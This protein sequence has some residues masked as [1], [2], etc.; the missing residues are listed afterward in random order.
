MDGTVTA[1]NAGADGVYIKWD[2]VTYD[3]EKN[4]K[5]ILHGI[6]GS[7]APGEMLAIMGPSGCGK[8]SLIN[9]LAQRRRGED[10]VGGTVE[11]NGA[12]I[13]H[14]QFARL[15]GYVTQ[16]FVKSPATLL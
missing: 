2:N 8:S 6:S 14:A 15:V 4:T 11:V 12:A 10:S 3:V 13:D 1:T 5:Q 16:D 9:I 7:V